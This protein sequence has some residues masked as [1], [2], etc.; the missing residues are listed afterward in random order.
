MSRLP[1]FMHTNAPDSVIQITIALNRHLDY[2][3]DNN[4]NICKGQH[5]GYPSPMF[6][7]PKLRNNAPLVADILF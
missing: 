2:N 1:I 3:I 4:K 7:L 6:L 5:F